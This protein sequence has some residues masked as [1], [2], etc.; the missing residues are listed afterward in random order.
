MAITR[1]A[2]TSPEFGYGCTRPMGHDDR[3]QVCKNQFV[4]AVWCSLCDE[5]GCEHIDPLVVAESA[6]AVKWSREEF[7]NLVARISKG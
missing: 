3:G 5:W 6:A 7:A 2:G 4:G 1:C